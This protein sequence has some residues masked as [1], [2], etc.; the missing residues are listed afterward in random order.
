MF[1]LFLFTSGKSNA[2]FWID[3]NLHFFY[4]NGKKNMKHDVAFGINL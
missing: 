3:N 2:F 4:K 1:L